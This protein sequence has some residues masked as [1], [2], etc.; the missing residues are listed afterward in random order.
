[1]DHSRS[2]FWEDSLSPFVL[3][4]DASFAGNG[5]I[6]ASVIYGENKIYSK[7]DNVSAND[8]A[9]GDTAALPFD[10]SE[11]YNFPIAPGIF[12]S[13][14]LGASGS[15]GL[16]YDGICEGIGV[17]AEAG[18]FFKATAYAQAAVGVGFVVEGVPVGVDAGLKC[19]VQLIDE[20]VNLSVNTGL[21]FKGSIALT[22]EVRVDNDLDALSGSLTGFLNIPY[23]HEYDF[24]IFNWGGV[25][26]HSTLFDQKFYTPLGIT[27]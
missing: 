11:A 10:Q 23:V 18:P 19:Q 15:M 2:G 5:A 1:M 22:E 20:R 3:T 12:I 21:A 24:Q 27:L 8:G 25:H 16:S 4:A 17:F 6:N 14:Q 7:S 13:G 26:Q 9:F